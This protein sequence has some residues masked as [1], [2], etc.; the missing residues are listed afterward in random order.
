M[1][2]GKTV[3]QKPKTRKRTEKSALIPISTLAAG[4]EGIITKNAC[5]KTSKILK[6][7]GI[8]FDVKVAS[9]DTKS[10]DANMKTLLGDFRKMIRS[11]TKSITRTAE[12]N[13]LK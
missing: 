11:E 5:G 4:K 1:T 10:T 2:T 12:K 8:N 6:R 7:S 13:R 3:A 9:A